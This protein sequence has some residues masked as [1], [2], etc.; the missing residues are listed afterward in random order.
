MTMRA[1]FHYRHMVSAL[2]RASIEEWFIVIFVNFYHTISHHKHF[3]SVAHALLCIWSSICH[4][5]KFSTLLRDMITRQALVTTI[6]N[7]TKF[8]SNSKEKKGILVSAMKTIGSMRARV[9]T[10]V[11]CQTWPRRSCGS[12]LPDRFIYSRYSS[13]NFW[14]SICSSLGIL[15]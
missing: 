14:M 9:R 8:Q 2:A 10:R 11:R 13:P 15:L 1:L 12:S 5:S 7:T 3:S 6:M 4:L